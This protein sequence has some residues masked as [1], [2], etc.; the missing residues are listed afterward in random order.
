MQAAIGLSQMEKLQEFIERRNN[1]F[2]YL[3]KGFS[4]FKE[5]DLPTWENDSS[6]SWFGFP[7]TINENA[8]FSRIELLKFYEENNIGTRLLFGGNILLQ[9]AYFN[10]G[11]GEPTDFPNANIIAENTFWLGVF[12]G[13]N[14][15]MLDFVIEVTKR[16]IG[17][18]K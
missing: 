4:N 2:N 13:L 14:S 3:Y 12:P 9:P 11:Y 8:K 5:F 17:N 10:T 1:N 6:P 15:D 18:Q 7:V 16:F